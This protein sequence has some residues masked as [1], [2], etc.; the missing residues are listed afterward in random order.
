MASDE[1]ELE[2][3]LRRIR[4]NMSRLEILWQK[5]ENLAEEQEEGMEGVDGKSVAVKLH[6]IREMI[7]QVEIKL[8][9][10]E[11]S[12]SNTESLRFRIRNE[13]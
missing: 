6:R 4:E 9:R 12:V 2:E 7:N 10:L 1:D 13:V 8:D 11:E 5:I 3:V